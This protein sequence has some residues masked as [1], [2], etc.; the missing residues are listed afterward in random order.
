[1]STMYEA[2]VAGFRIFGT[3]LPMLGWMELFRVHVVQYNLSA[4]RT[5]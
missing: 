2:Y 1:M 5:V 4:K 3:G